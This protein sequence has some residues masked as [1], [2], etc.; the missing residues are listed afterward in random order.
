MTL[1]YKIFTVVIN[2][3]AI[4]LCISVVLN[5][6]MILS[7][8]LMMLSGFMMVSIILYA[9]F[10]NQFTKKVLQQQLVVKR[11]LKD[12]VKVNGIVSM[13]FS[14]MVIV[15]VIVRMGNPDDYVEAMKGYGVNMP[16][17]TITTFL[18][19]TLA[20]GI[21]LLIH[22]IWTFILLRKHSSLFQ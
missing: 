6:P 22:V 10:S 15:G 13:I 1:L 5:I 12:L 19:I 2:T 4:L 11:N 9:W 20:Y 8:P 21:I 14:L 18:Y 17:Q 3:V 16:L 7:S